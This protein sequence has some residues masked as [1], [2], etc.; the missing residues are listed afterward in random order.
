[1]LAHVQALLPSTARQLCPQSIALHGVVAKAQDLV[2]GPVEPHT[3]AL[4]TLIQLPL[5]SLPALQA[6]QHSHPNWGCP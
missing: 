6:E 4:S 1:M 5:Q 2:L 3:P